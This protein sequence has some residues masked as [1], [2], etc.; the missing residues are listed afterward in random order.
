MHSPGAAPRAAP[1]PACGSR[2]PHGVPCHQRWASP[3]GQSFADLRQ[4]QGPSRSDEI[5]D[6]SDLTLRKPSTVRRPAGARVRRRSGQQPP[7]RSAPA[8]A[9]TAPAAAAAAASSSSSGGRVSPIAAP[10]RPAGG[11]Q[12]YGGVGIDRALPLRLPII[13]APWMGAR[14]RRE[15][16]QGGGWAP[17]DRRDARDSL[18]GRRRAWCDAT[19]RSAGGE[20]EGVS[21]GCG[22]TPAA[23]RWASVQGLPRGGV[24]LSRTVLQCEDRRIASLDGRDVSH[25]VL[26]D[27][28]PA[29]HCCRWHP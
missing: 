12:E 11:R 8:P 7:A 26:L 2:R 27:R 20:G 23:L 21:C 17:G 3:I 9:G 24:P 14:G 5:N 19:D 29:E 13:F 15:R 10:G 16:R 18:T 1:E 4:G 22:R 6:L 28:K 25:P